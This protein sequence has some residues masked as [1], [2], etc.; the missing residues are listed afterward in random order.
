ML[1]DRGLLTQGDGGW[2]LT[3]HV[4]GLPESIQGI[5][6]ARLDTLSDDERAF[7]QDASVIGKTAWTGAAC[8]LTE[9]S[10]WQVD[11]LLHL[12]E[13]KQLVQR[14]RRSS[15]ESETE[16]N[17]TH[18]L[19]RDVAYSQIRRADR[20]QK[21]EAAAE[22]IDRLAGE[23]DDKAELVADHYAHALSLRNQVGEDTAGLVAQARAAFIDAARAANAL[24][25]H[26]A[27]A[28]HYASA[29][30]LTP[31]D[32]AKQR[33]ALLFG[34]AMAQFRA[35]TPSEHL[36]RAAVDAQVLAEDWESAAMVERLLSVWYE[37][38]EARGDEATIHLARGAEYAARCPPGDA[39]F[40]IAAD[41]AFNLVTSGHAE[42]AL[43][44]ANQMIPIA[45]QAGLEVG[46]ALLIAWRGYATV[47]LGDANGL[48]DIRSAADTLAKHGH[49][50]TVSAYGNL[51]DT[52]RG[53]GDLVA[54]D[55]A[56]EEADRWARRVA[57]NW[58]I[59]W[60]A[61][62]RALQAYH[63]ADWERAE[64]LLSQMDTTPGYNR[65]AASTVSGPIAL[66][67]G[68]FQTT[69]SDAEAIT[70]YAAST[71]NNDAYFHGMALATANH[72]AQGHRD[73]ALRTCQQFLTRWHEAGGMTSRATELCEIAPT[74][75]NASRHDEIRDAALSLPEASRWRDALL[76][77][78]D[79]H[80]ADAATLY[81]EIGS[82]PLAADA[83]LLAARQAADEGRTA[84]AHQHAEAVLAFSEETGASLYQQRAEVFIKASA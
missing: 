24:Y 60:I 68:D 66:A 79:Q 21:H 40:Q 2:R 53:L 62:E 28:R 23:R 18:A 71:G 39:M 78:A 4:E 19:T 76:A 58:H 9:R 13:R 69:L 14:A 8:R 59:D 74:L 65:I 1:Q 27:T 11:E 72:S 47:A 10:S 51:A 63:A 73:D 54:A 7:I 32:D 12:L 82:R 43:A 36:L 42:E 45:D 5:I 61:G 50:N 15:I 55:E 16:F 46:G 29:L 83:H 34:E 57:S 22:W 33:A 80:Y 17:F 70:A 56:Y 44:L 38:R 20:A 67:R 75:A 41:Q 49:P 81:N 84:D 3:G 37:E 31:P 6:A 25:A 26:T 35:D 77:I 64:S 52:L 30:E 48:K